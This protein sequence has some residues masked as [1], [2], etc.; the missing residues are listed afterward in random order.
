VLLKHRDLVMTVHPKR[1]MSE[2]LRLGSIAAKAIPVD[3]VTSF[4]RGSGR[5]E[6][7]DWDPRLR[8]ENVSRD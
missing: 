4:H 7:T 5:R 8:L 2:Q 1:G 3:G 6:W